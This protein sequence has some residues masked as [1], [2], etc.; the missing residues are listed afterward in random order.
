MTM[1]FVYYEKQHLYNPIQAKGVSGNWGS[2][3]S[4]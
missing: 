1:E 3:I 4:R 2:K